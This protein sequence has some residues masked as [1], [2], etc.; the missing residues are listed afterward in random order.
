[1]HEGNGR[2]RANSNQHLKTTITTGRRRN[3]I[4]CREEGEKREGRNP[5]HKKHE[6]VKQEQTVSDN[7]KTKRLTRHTYLV[8]DYCL[9]SN[10]AV[11]AAA[12]AAEV[13]RGSSLFFSPPKFRPF[14]CVFTYFF[15]IFA[16]LPS[17]LRCLSP[18]R[19]PFVVLCVRAL[20]VRLTAVI[21]TS[22]QALSIILTRSLPRSP[23]I[24]RTITQTPQV[25]AILLGTCPILAPS[26]LLTLPAHPLFGAG[27]SG[28][29]G[30]GGVCGRGDARWCQGQQA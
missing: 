11:A 1:M 13:S 16:C 6:D 8:K 18:P 15:I 24:S 26:W 9:A 23:T 4:K 22:L 20:L 10:A 28:C 17:Y 25:I 3:I 27:G 30:G 12:A 7:E 14:K 29:W 21:L 2:K 5:K 19:L